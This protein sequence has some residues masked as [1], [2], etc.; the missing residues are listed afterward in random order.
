MKLKLRKLQSKCDLSNCLSK[1]INNSGGGSEEENELA[2]VITTS[3]LKSKLQKVGLERRQHLGSA[4]SNKISS[5]A[6]EIKFRSFKKFCRQLTVLFCKVNFD[7]IEYFLKL[8]FENL[9]KTLQFLA[10]IISF[11]SRTFYL[12]S[13]WINIKEIVS[14][15][16]MRHLQK[17]KRGG[18]KLKGWKKEENLSK[19]A[20]F[21]IL[22][23]CTT[24]FKE[25]ISCRL[26]IS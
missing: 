15:Y 9:Y 24:F 18:R 11:S 14:S 4:S 21:V 5:L 19:S 8:I 17:E 25:I 22:L 13:I 23:L 6:K 10:K 1:W 7:R 2:K 26:F 12:Q 20:A 3:R 16:I